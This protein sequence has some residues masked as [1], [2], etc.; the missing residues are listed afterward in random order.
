[1]PSFPIGSKVILHNLKKGSQYNGKHGVV[2][3]SPTN[4]NDGRQ[5]VFLHESQKIV[6]V[7]PDNIQLVLQ[8]K[9]DGYVQSGSFPIGSNVMIQVADGALG[10]EWNGKRGT[11][12]TDIDDTGRQDVQLRCGVTV[13]VKSEFLFVKESKPGSGRTSKKKERG[14][15]RKAAKDVPIRGL[16]SIPHVGS[17]LMAVCQ[18]GSAFDGFLSQFRKGDDYATGMLTLDSSLVKFT[19]GMDFQNSGI[20]SSCLGLL[21]RCEDESFE[22]VMASLGGDLVSPTMWIKVLWRAVEEDCGTLQIA[23]GIGPLARCM[24][25]DSP[26]LFFN[27]NEYW[28]EAIVPFVKMIF[29]MIRSSIDSNGTQ[30]VRSEKGKTII[31]A[32]FQHDA[33]LKSIIQW[34]FW[35]EERNDIMRE[36]AESKWIV[37]L[38]RKGTLLLFA[39]VVTEVGL[40]VPQEYKNEME[41]IGAVSVDPSCVVSFVEGLIRRVKTEGWLS[42][43][44]REDLALITCLVEHADCVD[45]GVIVGMIDV[46]SFAFND[47]RILHVDSDSAEHESV[48]YLER[49]LHVMLIKGTSIKKSHP[50]DTRVALAIRSGLVEMCLTYI[51][52]VGDRGS[53]SNV[54]WIENVLGV[55]NDVSLHQKSWKAIR[56][57][58]KDIEEKLVH[59]NQSRATNNA[60]CRKLLGMV[61]SILYLNG[62]YCCRCNKSLR[63]TEVKLCNGCGCMAYCSRECQTEDWLLNGHNLAC[64]KTYT[65]KMVGQFQGRGLPATVPASERDAIKLKEVEINISMI[66][67]KLFLDCS[68]TILTQ[69]GRQ[70]LP[71]CDCVVRFDLRDCPPLVKVEKYDEYFAQSTTIKCFEDSRSKENITCSYISS[72]YFG[73]SDDSEPVLFCLQR[74]FP[75]KWLTEKQ[76]KHLVQQDALIHTKNEKVPILFD[77]IMRPGFAD[78][79]IQGNLEAH[80]NGLHFISTSGEVVDVLYSNIKH[81]IFQPCCEGD[82][83]VLVHFH[84]R[85]AIMVGNKIQQDVQFSFQVFESANKVENTKER[86]IGLRL[87]GRINNVFK[88]FAKNVEGMARKNEYQLEFDIPYQDLGF[89]GNPNEEMV[90][91]VPTLNCLCN[92]TETPF[93]VVDLSMIDHVHFERVTFMG[94]SFDMVMTNK[95]FTKQP[96]RVNMIPNEDKDSI[97]VRVVICCAW[98]S[99]FIL[100]AYICCIFVY[101]IGYLTW[102]FHSQ[103]GPMNLK[104]LFI[105]MHQTTYLAWDHQLT[106]LVGLVLGN[107]V[108]SR[109]V[110]RKSSYS[111]MINT[112]RLNIYLS[113]YVYFSRFYVC[114]YKVNVPKVMY[115][116]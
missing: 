70:N 62:S 54:R 49:I 77:V 86:E 21:Q 107:D 109:K 12:K 15:Q 79:E 53:E 41:I 83:I 65:D 56:H 18:E 25:T 116:Q 31:D 105:G 74:F 42:F 38:G 45:K 115:D 80:S 64:C 3:S 98:N 1:M 6:A 51:D 11:V 60:T 50:C 47:T 34:A 44:G 30:P 90:F 103:M 101:R 111:E 26:R 20:L 92:L 97:T 87:M 33:L 106:R 99:F 58:R 14:K 113:F 9:E 112:Y 5:N 16:T 24:S 91:V 73:R 46:G 35:G 7:K 4:D 37:D 71:L 28:K 93:F 96:W 22:R 23:Q 39:G 102:R 61:R 59:S 114:T 57:K 75:H 13:G 19:G 43:S 55:V 82:I 29:E 95:D 110:A 108:S 36:V 94:S 88:D 67:L 104:L 100:F 66:Q 85:N 84:L 81:A 32:L 40:D 2:K 69:A 52:L 17:N 27:S 78:N 8:K 63:R 89:M 48:L 72:I 76:S 68:E 10:S